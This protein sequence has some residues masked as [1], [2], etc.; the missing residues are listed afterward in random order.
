[1]QIISHSTLT[2]STYVATLLFFY[3]HIK[4]TH[5]PAYILFSTAPNT[6]VSPKAAAFV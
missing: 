1:M 6:T 2:S 3:G 5:K 4:Y